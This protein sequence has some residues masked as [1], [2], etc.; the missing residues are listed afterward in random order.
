MKKSLG[1]GIFAL[2]TP[3]WV[4]GSYDKQGKANAMTIAWGGVCCSKPPCLAISLRQATYTY[5]CIMERGAF[6]V[7]IPSEKQ[8][9]ETDFF[10]MASG[11]DV[12]KFARTGLTPVKAESVDAPYIK[13]FSLVVEC[14]LLH[15]V[16]IGLHT[17][18]IG[19]VK[20]V[21]ADESVL[22]D[23]VPVMDKVL[24][25]LYGTGTKTYFKTGGHLGKSFSIGRGHMK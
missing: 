11:K 14:S 7:N 4:V 16:E 10:G 1:A 9:V 19:E 15:T 24:P 23:G 6:T 20:D 8:A 3:A 25:I 18:F 21:L 22:V 2:P 12:D 17:Q 13:E 5:G